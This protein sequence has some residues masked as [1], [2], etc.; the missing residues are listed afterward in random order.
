MSMS[1]PIADLLT[2]VRNAQLASHEG[3]NVRYSKIKKDILEILKNEGFIKDYKMISKDN[4]SSLE[5]K[6]KYNNKIPVIK[7]LLRVSKPGRRVY[8]AHEE[9]KPVR[10]NLGVGIIST[11]QGLM[12]ARKA[13]KLGIGGEMLCTIF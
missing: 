9:I 7:E 1:D 10:N 5:V 11:S 2:R 8:L 4:K 12:T 3:L 6:L 13:K